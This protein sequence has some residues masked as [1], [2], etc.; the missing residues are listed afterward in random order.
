MKI[1]ILA[2]L[3]LLGL[4]C[5]P[6][7]CKA[8]ASPEPSDKTIAREEKIGRKGSIEVEKAIPRV[9]DPAAEA[10]LAM[11]TDKL[12]PYLQRNLDYSVRILDMKAPNA[13]SLPG[14]HTYIKRR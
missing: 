4:L 5:A 7:P 13:F 11:I 14:G 8:A 1:K 2:I 3:L 9:L 6:A 10:K 12:T